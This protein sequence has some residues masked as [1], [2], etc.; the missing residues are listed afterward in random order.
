MDIWKPKTEICKNG[1]VSGSITYSNRQPFRTN[2]ISL[3]HEVDE[4]K[5]IKKCRRRHT[6]NRGGDEPDL[7][8]KR[9]PPDRQW[10]STTC[11]I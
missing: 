3:I 7:G 1:K 10:L 6:Q 5:C 9:C 8:T 4:G 2:M 11:K